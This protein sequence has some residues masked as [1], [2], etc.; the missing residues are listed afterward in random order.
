MGEPSRLDRRVF[1]SSLAAGLVTAH[2]TSAQEHSPLRIGLT[3]VFLDNE[4]QVLENLRAHIGRMTGRNAEFIQRRTY[5]EVV[6]LLLLGELDAAWLCGYPLLQRPNRLDALAIPI[7]RG[8]PRYQAYIIVAQDRD[9]DTLF[10]LKGDIHAYSDPDSNSGHL[11]TVTQILDL[12]EPPE[13]F[14]D[15]SFFTFGHRNVVRAV[16]QRLAGSGSVDG[17]VYE[18]L[19]TTEPALVDRTRVLWRSD[20]H[21][22]PPFVI[23]TERRDTTATAALSRALFGI[24]ETEEGRM[25][26][27][28]LQLDGFAH[29]RPDSFDSIASLMASVADRG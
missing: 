16:A 17:Y 12:N 28:Q 13:A 10:D 8:Q 9:A 15:T 3:P 18:A 6:A 23:A 21:G 19:M 20:W 1:L 29:P 27:R 4:W 7:W 11:V 25:V 2:A 22:F 26:L 5:Q 24:N 14:F